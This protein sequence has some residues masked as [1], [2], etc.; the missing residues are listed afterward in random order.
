[1]PFSHSTLWRMV[2]RGTFPAP[3]AL[4]ERIRV[5]PETVVDEW[6]AS[7]KPSRDARLDSSTKRIRC[8]AP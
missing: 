4:T 1:M 5:W 8:D 7:R 2:A 6:L 3:I